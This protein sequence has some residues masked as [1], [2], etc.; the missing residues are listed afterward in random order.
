MNKFKKLLLLPFLVTLSTQADDTDIYTALD[1]GVKIKKRAVFLMDTSGSMG[2]RANSNCSGSSCETRMEVVQ[3]VARDVISDPQFDDMEIALM[4]FDHTNNYNGGYLLTD[5]MSLS[6]DTAQNHLLNQI[7]GLNTF[8]GTPLKEAISEAA[9]FLRGDDSLYSKYYDPDVGCSSHYET[10]NNGNRDRRACFSLKAGTSCTRKENDYV[11]FNSGW[12]YKY[13]ICTEWQPSIGERSVP[14]SFDTPGKYKTAFEQ[15]CDAP[16]IIAFTDG[17]SSV[18][19]AEDST[20]LN[21]YND[22]IT[23]GK[24]PSPAI[25]NDSQHHQKLAF[26]LNNQDHSS[27]LKGDQSIILNTIGGFNDNLDN[28]LQGMANHGGG[29]FGSGSDYTTLKTALSK[30]INNVLD[31]GS[32]FVAPQVAVSSDNTLEVGSDVYVSL[33]KPAK[34]AKWSGNVKR[35]KRSPSGGI[36]DKGDENGENGKSVFDVN[37]GLFSD[38]AHSFWSKERDGDDI[39]KGGIASHIENRKLYTTNQSNSAAILI[40]DENKNKE[41]QQSEFNSSSS[42][43]SLTNYLLNRDTSGNE[44]KGMADPLHS[45]PL[46]VTYASGERTL[47]ITTNA[48][49]LHAFNPSLE[50]EETGERYAFI[51]R[52]LLPKAAAYHDQASSKVYGLDLTPYLWHKD[53]NG[54]RKID[55][56][57]KAYLYLGMRRGGRDYYVVDISN[58]NQPTFIR[59]ITGGSSSFSRLGQTWATPVRSRIQWDGKS[60]DVLIISGGYDGNQNTTP[61]TVRSSLESS[62]SMGNDIFVIDPETSQLLWKA[63]NVMTLKHAIPNRPTMIDDNSDGYHDMMYVSD[64]SGKIIRFDFNP[65]ATSGNNFAKGGVL[66]DMAS[67]SNITRFFSQPDISFVRY[68][69]Q[70]TVPDQAEKLTESRYQLAIGSGNRAIPNGKSI[71][72]HF[73]VFYDFLDKQKLGITWDKINYTNTCITEGTQQVEPPSDLANG[74]YN[75]NTVCRDN[76]AESTVSGTSS[77]SDFQISRQGF[78]FKLPDAGEKVLARGLTVNNH[79]VFSSFQPRSANA[80]S[81]QPSGG[82]TRRWT[83]LFDNG[84][85]LSSVDTAYPGIEDDIHF[86]FIEEPGNGEDEKPIT[87]GPLPTI[88]NGFTQ[89]P[90]IDGASGRPYGVQRWQVQ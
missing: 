8:G 86:D 13:N 1:N 2:W 27:S 3:Q 78:Y 21:N 50:E 32:T 75:I 55:S 35:Y 69:I 68:S 90:I 48:G 24:N 26:W 73:F 49:F 52:D 89:P 83:L 88:N 6:D 81:C 57:E 63:S 12:S 54:D 44:L 5:F 58:I 37:T 25:E 70:P 43:D 47:F 72:N 38:K 16:H 66:A 15:T 9:R 74:T 84:F 4:R 23:A 61:D 34:G 82:K 22:L 85:N 77:F 59:R 11:L 28:L 76:L 10:W 87:T 62:S 80:T 19:V 46:V 67:G 45:K 79:I 33:F 7:N 64:V 56:G 65:N 17:E 31:N 30:A 42:L 53:T 39:E 14:E 20:I 29:T 60:K 18:D 36:I 41:L 71:Q 51:P 40:N